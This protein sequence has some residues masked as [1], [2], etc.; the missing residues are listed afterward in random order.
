MS[1][2]DEIPVIEKS[3]ALY[4][5][6][7][8]TLERL[9]TKLKVL[10]VTKTEFRQKSGFQIGALTGPRLKR[11]GGKRIVKTT[12]GLGLARWLGAD[13]LADPSQFTPAVSETPG[14]DS[15]ICLGPAAPASAPVLFTQ[16]RLPLVREPAEPPPIAAA[17][18]DPLPQLDGLRGTPSFGDVMRIATQG[19]QIQAEVA[20][21]RAQQRHQAFLDE[22]RARVRD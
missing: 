2:L 6:C 3:E 8:V 12:Y 14:P 21:D 22:V 4:I 11:Q 15:V 18:P 7:E 13:I 5:F 10:N 19:R 20:L 17:A 9:L 1:G 16:P